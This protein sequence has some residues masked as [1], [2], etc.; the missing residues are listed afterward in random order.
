V[1][2]RTLGSPA[3]L[4]QPDYTT[5]APG[6]ALTLQ[7]DPSRYPRGLKETD[8][9]IAWWDRDHRAWA[10]L[11][12][13]VDVQRKTITTQ[14]NHFTLFAVVPR[15][16]PPVRWGL[17]AA[18]LA[19]EVLAGAA[20]LLVLRRRRAMGRSMDGDAL[21]DEGDELALEAA[22]LAAFANHDLESVAANPQ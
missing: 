15:G 4:L 21:G 10:E 3:V 12:S 11:P 16:A 13:R 9:V 5:F 14:V 20:A 22:P 17:V 2:S 7:Y 1:A 6:F 8:L 19:V 18:I